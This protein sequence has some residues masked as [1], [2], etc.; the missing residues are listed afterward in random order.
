MRRSLAVLSRSWPPP[1]VGIGPLQPHREAVMQ[2]SFRARV[3]ARVDSLEIVRQL[4]D[5]PP[6]E[7]YE[8]RVDRRRAVLKR[9]AG[10]TGTAGIEGAVI[11]FVGGRTDVPVP[12]ILLRTSDFYVADWHPQAPSPGEGATPDATWTRAAGQGLARLHEQTAPHLE[13][14]GIFELEAGDLGIDDHP[15]WADAV[16]DYLGRRRRAIEPYGHADIADTVAE[17]LAARAD[18]FEGTGEAVCC[19]GWATPDHIAVDAGEVACMVDFEH[20][21]AAPG[22][23]DIWRTLLPLFGPSPDGPAVRAFVEGYETVRRLPD[24]FERREPLYRLLNGVYYFESLYVQDQHDAE[25]TAERAARLR[26]NI[27]DLIDALR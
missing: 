8:I 25:A 5:V 17:F 12:E 9:D 15:R 19:H 7:V 16:Q 1:A 6:H 24:G 22:E 14:Y 27:T 13:G 21:I 26:T 3:A 18:R 11:E 23:F 4:H 10:P 20:A 2:D